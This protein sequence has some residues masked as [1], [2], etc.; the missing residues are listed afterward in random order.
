VRNGGL[1]GDNLILVR[2]MTDLQ[3]MILDRLVGTKVGKNWPDGPLA[4]AAEVIGGAKPIEFG[5][6]DMDRGAKS[7]IA[8]RLGYPVLLCEA[9]QGGNRGLPGEDDRR[10]F[11]MNVFRTIPIAGPIPKLRVLAQKRIAGQM[12][13]RAH[14]HLCEQPDCPLLTA[15]RELVEA[16]TVTR[17]LTDG[18]YHAQCAN[19]RKSVAT[20]HQWSKRMDSEQRLLRAVY[21]TIHGFASS[22]TSVAGWCSIRESV[23]LT[24]SEGG[25][26]E[27]VACC[28]EI[29]RLCGMTV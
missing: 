27:V 25:V 16:E 20:G 29:A 13:I 5:V 21:H 23:R 10:S 12:V 9:I 15:L 18:V 11:A 22:R 3:D 4:I 24:A 17:Q 19:I 6:T 8:R 2:A 26:G 7:E 1:I 14:S 28:V